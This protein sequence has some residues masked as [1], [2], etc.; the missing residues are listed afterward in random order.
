MQLVNF[1][2]GAEQSRVESI[3][4]RSHQILDIDIS[5][6]FVQQFTDMVV[7]VCGVMASLDQLDGSRRLFDVEVPDQFIAPTQLGAQE[8]GIVNLSGIALTVESQ[9]LSNG[10]VAHLDVDD[11]Q[12]AVV[13]EFE[14]DTV[15]CECLVDITK[16]GEFFVRI[17]SNSS[18][19][20]GSLGFTIST[21]D[22]KQRLIKFH[23]MLQIQN[24]TQVDITVAI[25][26]GPVLEGSPARNWT[27]S[28]A[29][30]FQ[31]PITNTLTLSKKFVH[32]R[33][34][35][36]ASHPSCYSGY[37][38][39][40]QKAEGL[41]AEAST[42]VSIVYGT[43][44]ARTSIKP[45]SHAP[46]WNEKRYVQTP[47]EGA[48]DIMLELWAYRNAHSDVLLGCGSLTP[49]TVQNNE[50]VVVDVV[51]L[52]E[53]F[54]KVATLHVSLE[55]AD[56]GEEGFTSL[57]LS[58][59]PADGEVLRLCY[60][61]FACALCC[62][63]KDVQDSEEMI[64]MMI[65]KS[66][67]ENEIVP[68]WVRQCVDAVE[69][70][71]SGK[72]TKNDV[73]FATRMCVFK[74]KPLLV[75]ENLLC[76]KLWLQTPDGSEYVVESGAQVTLIERPIYAMQARTADTDWSTEMDLREVIRKRTEPKPSAL[77]DLYLPQTMSKTAWQAALS[78]VPKAAFYLCLC[79]VNVKN[80]EKS[81]PL[82]KNRFVVAR[83]GNDTRRTSIKTSNLWGEYLNYA[84]P[85]EGNLCVRLSCVGDSWRGYYLIGSNTLR[86][87][88]AKT[89]WECYP[90]DC[91]EIKGKRR[92]HVYLRKPIDRSFLGL[93]PLKSEGE[94]KATMTV[95]VRVIQVER[96]EEEVPDGQE[97]TASKDTIEAIS[98]ESTTT[99][100]EGSSERTSSSS[101][102]SEG[103]LSLHA[104]DTEAPF[105][106]ELPK[107]GSSSSIC[108]DGSFAETEGFTHEKDRLRDYEKVET[109]M[110]K[111]CEYGVPLV[112]SVEQVVNAHGSA[113]G[114]HLALFCKYQVLN[115]TEY[116]LGINFVDYPMKLSTLMGA[117]ESSCLLPGRLVKDRV[118][119]SMLPHNR[120]R[121]SSLYSPGPKKHQSVEFRYR[122]KSS[123][124]RNIAETLR[125]GMEVAP[126]VPPYSRT[127]EIRLFHAVTME[128][129]SDSVVQVRCVLPT[130]KPRSHSSHETVTLLC[131]DL[132]GRV[133]LVTSAEAFQLRLAE[134]EKSDPQP[135]ERSSSQRYVPISMWSQPIPIPVTEA[136]LSMIDQD[137][138][139][140]KLLRV[141]STTTNGVTILSFS[142]D[143]PPL[144]ILSNRT[145]RT[146]VIRQQNTKDLDHADLILPPLT[147]SKFGWVRLR[148][149]RK[150]EVCMQIDEG[151][152]R[153]RH[154]ED[155]L[156]AVF[157][158]E[159]EV[160][161]LESSSIIEAGI[162]LH[163]T[164][165]LMTS[166]RQVF[167]DDEGTTDEAEK[168]FE[169]S[170]KQYVVWVRVFEVKNIRK[171]FGSKL[172]GAG[173]NTR[174]TVNS[175]TLETGQ[176]V[177]MDD[178][179]DSMYWVGKS[180][181][182][183]C[184]E[185]PESIDFKLL[186]DVQSLNTTMEYQF[187]EYTLELGKEELPFGVK[188]KVHNGWVEMHSKSGAN[189]LLK[190]QV[191]IRKNALQAMQQATL[192]FRFAGFGLSII[193]KGRE[194]AYLQVRGVDLY[195]RH[196][197]NEMHCAL[198]VGFCQVLNQAPPVR[199]RIVL[200]PTVHDIDTLQ[201]YLLVKTFNHRLIHLERLEIV[202]QELVCRLEDSFLTG[203][204]SVFE[205]LISNA[206]LIQ[207]RFQQANVAIKNN[208]VNLYEDVKV[209]ST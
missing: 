118:F 29:S 171:P 76:E 131:D 45:R 84:V 59:L 204:F 178:V 46:V 44:R 16:V 120:P 89:F 58:A 47:E 86:L 32:F 137:G 87:S 168:V 136:P 155:E 10:D 79:V 6:Q 83:L 49:S 14:S 33:P 164:V 95:R 15:Q 173:A 70:C 128:N 43:S 166:S 119:L 36:S 55:K 101:S 161:R 34:A 12:T 198:S 177:R 38:V 153:N 18:A 127:T 129:T 20:L 184:T 17:K 154:L 81:S 19:D 22:G 91:R 149:K 145:S 157:D 96:P 132:T 183:T 160:G 181:L 159:T 40:V 134:A 189:P 207:Q 62:E 191:Y 205:A 100:T 93:V 30:T 199:D 9:L 156:T 152:K 64:E 147:T 23:S 74:L 37:H 11:N 139:E 71:R 121:A 63:F 195:L 163:C 8:I 68:L 141:R 73:P 13:V 186:H 78:S 203:V 54:G 150:V 124:G 105:D 80:V 25:N 56:T 209:S 197:E 126:M 143:L 85:E 90:N 148:G 158:I 82:Y 48:E 108:Q 24:L 187:G 122:Y 172:V 3:V 51:N 169:N 185:Q 176:S 52:E 111:A 174:V 102:E 35:A 57:D 27:I 31:V 99:L 61:C 69:S 202:L 39:S 112:V 60:G 144:F 53:G 50:T 92:N 188:E 162:E 4:V 140:V 94:V 192:C 2:L 26:D 77:A 180:L 196:I 106:Q 104:D 201:V 179:S 116:D 182:F 75:V 98:Q 125:F 117:G 142:N 109:L 28:P 1:E 114:Y 67:A 7:D 165:Q 175:T 103:L 138:K 72:E 206:R 190:F 113:A 107:I 110:E 194:E 130:N 135:G 146:L 21:R 65:R 167:F 115:Q 97:S 170:D 5:R 66:L 133:P 151:F 200:S 42:F 123:S 193:G 88:S 41:Q 208:A